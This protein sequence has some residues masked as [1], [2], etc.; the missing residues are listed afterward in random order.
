MANITLAIPEE[1][2][3][4]MRRHKDLRWSGLVRSV[5]EEKINDLE[6]M[7]RLLA[8]SRLTEKDALEI[9]EKIKKAVAKRLG[10]SR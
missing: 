5:I 6:A 4:K 10:F 3:R 1:L 8:K 2:H 7:D 9:S